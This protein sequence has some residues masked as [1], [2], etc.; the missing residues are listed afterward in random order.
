MV[1]VPE[2]DIEQEDEAPLAEDARS[3]SLDSRDLDEHYLIHKGS[4]SVI[5]WKC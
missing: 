3:D 2:G 4:Q 1:V 5:L